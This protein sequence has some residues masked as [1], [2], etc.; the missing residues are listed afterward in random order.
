MSTPAADD[1]A[2]IQILRGL[3]REDLRRIRDA[4]ELLDVPAGY[5]LI[6]EGAVPHNLILLIRGRLEVYIPDP[7]DRAQG[8]RL[9]TINPGDSCGEYGFVDRR[10][11]SASVKALE[12]SAVFE[13]HHDELNALMQQRRDLERVFHRNL[14]NTL[15]NRLRA[16]N[17]VIDLLRSPPE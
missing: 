9:A 10:P 17:V 15:V 5:R 13:L 4:G 14:L 16:S 12:N 1:L 11:T 8:K 3:D 6:E 2:G 7:A